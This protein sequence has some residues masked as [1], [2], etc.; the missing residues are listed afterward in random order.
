[1]PVKKVGVSTAQ[2]PIRLPPLNR[3]NVKRGGAGDKNPC[4]SIMSSVLT[5][6]ASNGFNVA[7]CQ[8]LET[9]LRSCMDSSKNRIQKKNTVN[10]HLARMLPNVVNPKKR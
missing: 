4:L 7:G 10:Y 6:W 9:Q 5:C 1:M 2:K 3:L 8:N